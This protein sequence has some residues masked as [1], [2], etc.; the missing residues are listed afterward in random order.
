V[1]KKNYNKSLNRKIDS[2]GSILVLLL[3][4]YQVPAFV[5]NQN[6]N[7]ISQPTTLHQWGAISLFHGLP[8]DRVRAIVQDKDGTMWF[9]TDGGLV[10]Y[11]G[12]RIQAITD[13]SLP[14]G[15]ILALNLDETGTLWIGT[16]NGAARL[17]DERFILVEESA[18]KPI[19]AII[20]PQPG[21]AILASE[22]AIFDCYSNEEELK[23]KVFNEHPKFSI[24]SSNGN[25]PLHITSLAFIENT[26]WAG[27][28]GRG[29]IT[30][31]DG[32]IKEIISRPRAYF[33]EAI[34]K[35]RQGTVWFGAQTRADTGGLY[36]FSDPLRPVKLASNIGTVTSIHIDRSGNY[37]IGTDGH[38]A[39]R[40][41]GNIKQEQFTFEGTAG[42]LRSN[43]IY[44]ILADREG[45]VWFGTDRGLC[46][47]DPSAPKAEV[48][49]TTPNSNFIRTLYQSSDG[50]LWSGTN[51][52]LFLYKDQSWQHVEELANRAVYTVSQDHLSR[53]LVGTSNGLY[54]KSLSDNEWNQVE[55]SYTTEK[56]DEK[57]DDKSVRATAILHGQ[58]YIATFGRGLERLTGDK[59]LQ[60]TLIWP[61]NRTDK[62]EQEIIS[63]HVD[64]QNQ[65]WIGTANLGAFI[66]DGKEVRPA[67]ESFADINGSA[68]RAIDGTI[69]NWLWFGTS[70]GV[71]VYHNGKLANYIPNYDVR[72]LIV[73]SNEPS[74]SE[75]WCATYGD[76]LLRVAVDEKFGVVISK[77][78][79]E[80][81]LSSQSAFALF[82]LEDKERRSTL[83][84]GTNRGLTRYIS[85]TVP[86]TLKVTRILSRHLHQ[87]SEIRTGLHL[88]Y[89]QNSL[90]LDVNAVSSRTF[91]EQFQYGF[92]LYNTKGE[93]IKQRLSHDP[94]FLMENLKPG[95]YRVWIRAFTKDLITSEPFQFEFTVPKAPFPWSIAALTTMLV[96]ALI[97]L[98]WGAWQNR[99]MA[100]TSADLTRAN[101][102]LAKAK[103]QLA[104]EAE[105]ERRR[106]ARDLHDQTLA[107]LRGLLLLTDQLPTEGSNKSDANTIDPA[108]FRS[109]IESISKEIRRICE[110]L[111]PSVLE[112]VGLTAAL[113]WALAD[114]VKHLP[115][116]RKFEYQ[117]SCEE[118]IED[119][120]QL[121]PSIRIQIYRII[122]EVISNI[123]RH[124]LP[125]HVSSTAKLSPEGELTITIE[126]NGQS[127]NYKDKRVRTGRGLTNIRARASLIE[128]EVNW[129]TRAEGG[130]I[131][132]LRKTNAINNPPTN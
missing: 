78:D 81:G 89:P 57:N 68:I 30:I 46:R 82:N 2:L 83:L 125:T 45:V 63:L 61:L 99:R 84:I 27:T 116:E 23:V 36:Q 94:Q 60:R 13:A 20:T 9:G 75:A 128:A 70:R 121:S 119:R 32:E 122:Q 105:T 58:T 25:Q 17:I 15:R 16:D 87:L 91:P 114:A 52:G 86:P 107:D 14:H 72:D 12:R 104:N 100:R 22:G 74:L 131:F 66:Y 31:K 48:L 76:G 10:K 37:W 3:L 127:F 56:K 40:Y 98:W 77:L 18:G 49:S 4:F 92:I 88:N 102:K 59:S 118:D 44:S 96:C 73:G 19:T 111:S 101:R 120:L 79:V 113:E 24:E 109:E 43:S 28:H 8:S 11:D 97:A 34:E 124:A 39:F 65:I 41:S 90:A 6:P 117:F 26:I 71:Y 69:N 85:G 126:D 7:N 35:D 123:C 67:G 50:Q 64:Q 21:R 55:E 42:G 5:E 129:S 106:I 110:D 33:V 29:L 53:L 95:T 51:E 62:R 112:N 132:T 47:Y 115:H 1:F 93:V 54:I 38:G 80:Q 103:L 130:T 108:L